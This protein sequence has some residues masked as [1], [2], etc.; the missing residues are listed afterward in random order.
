MK[1]VE[2]ADAKESLATYAQHKENFPVVV[3]DHGQPVAALLSLENTDIETASL[4][5][6]QQFL[7]LIERS[8]K[9]CAEK[10]VI[11]SHEMRKRCE[12]TP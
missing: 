1:T 9:S 7:T 12:T 10:D 6:N 8:R 3:T 2:I 4:S 11:S 5:T